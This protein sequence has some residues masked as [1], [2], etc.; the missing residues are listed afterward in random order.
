M[1]IKKSKV[2]TG[3]QENDSITTAN[4]RLTMWLNVHLTNFGITLNT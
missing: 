4:M 2:M 3:L 1:N